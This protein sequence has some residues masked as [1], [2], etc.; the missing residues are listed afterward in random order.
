MKDI[1]SKMVAISVKV[2]ILFTHACTYFFH[3]TV[4]KCPVCNNN[5]NYTYMY[6]HVYLR[7]MA[8]NYTSKWKLPLIYK[9][10]SKVINSQ[11][12]V[13]HIS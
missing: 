7:L 13:C 2:N 3:G 8:Y 9:M 11:I 12:H 10:V 6:I 4:V 1:K 5:Y